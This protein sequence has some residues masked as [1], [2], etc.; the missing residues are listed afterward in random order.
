VTGVNMTLN[1]DRCNDVPC[2]ATNLF[3]ESRTN[4]STFYLYNE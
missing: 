2:A 3:V 1:I 4:S